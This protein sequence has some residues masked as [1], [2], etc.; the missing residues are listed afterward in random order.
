MRCFTSS[1]SERGTITNPQWGYKTAPS[2]W[3]SF[4]L[5]AATEPNAIDDAAARS[6][7]VP[8]LLGAVLIFRDVTQRRAAEE[9]Q[10]R[11]AAIVESS[12]DAIVSKNL[13]GIIQS[14]NSGAER[15]FGYT[16][17]EAIGK[18]IRILI[19]PERLEEEHEII[20]RIVN[21]ERVEHFDTV[22]VTKYGERI[23]ISLTVSP[24]R[25]RTGRIVGA[26]K[27]ARDITDRRRTE[28]ALREADQRKDQF[29]ALLAHELRNPLAPLRN[30][31]QVMRPVEPRHSRGGPGQP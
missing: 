7:I 6:T 25:D 14:W 12:Q 29:L 26:S 22:R 17:E 20:A 18:S 8:A 27:V 30:G 11:L 1:T 31:L 21:E 9:A 23:D 19:P 24:V 15:L 5:I 3:P 13:D 16:A 2:I 4:N 10:A 28:E